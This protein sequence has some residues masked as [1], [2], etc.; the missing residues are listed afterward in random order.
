MVRSRQQ[1][2]AKSLELK[3]EDS[4]FSKESR[5]HRGPKGRVYHEH[6]SPVASEQSSSKPSGGDRH[7][8]QKELRDFKKTA[9]KAA[10]KQD[11]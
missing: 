3:E 7:R 6:S 8:E 11:A 1:D 9:S 4:D 5:R 2:V 10:A